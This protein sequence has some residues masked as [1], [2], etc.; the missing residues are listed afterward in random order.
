MADYAAGWLK[1][2]GYDPGAIDEDKKDEDG[3]T[4]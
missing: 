3:E 2:H 1:D 4:R